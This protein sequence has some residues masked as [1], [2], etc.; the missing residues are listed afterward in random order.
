MSTTRQMQGATSPA[1]AQDATT[2]GGADPSP[3]FLSDT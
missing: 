2:I 1:R 3:V